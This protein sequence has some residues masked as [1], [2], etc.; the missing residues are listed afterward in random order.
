MIGYNLQN[1]MLLENE[2]THIFDHFYKLK[3][4]S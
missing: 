2:L 1:Q 4:N 3:K